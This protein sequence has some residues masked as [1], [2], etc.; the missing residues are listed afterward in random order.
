MNDE[1]KE[2]DMTP[3]IDVSFQLL[4]FFLLTV[5]RTMTESEDLPTVNIETDV[6]VPTGRVITVVDIVK[7]YVVEPEQ[8]S[9]GKSVPL[10]FNGV[11]RT[12][13]LE[14]LRQ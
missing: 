2:M 7:K 4:I 3:L 14:K 12:N 6:P 1:T 10:R 13:L 11:N 9:T 5:K 8:Q